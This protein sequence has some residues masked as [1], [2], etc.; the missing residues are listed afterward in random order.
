MVGEESAANNY[1][2]C[3]TLKKGISNTGEL[4]HVT[5]NIILLMKKMST[6]L[7]R[8]MLRR[9]RRVRLIN[10]GIFLNKHTSRNGTR[11]FNTY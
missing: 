10:E 11:T 5:K 4:C 8:G 2:G 3:V 7:V 6:Q 1:T 9:Q